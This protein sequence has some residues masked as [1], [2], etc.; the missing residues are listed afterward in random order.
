MSSCTKSMCDPIEFHF[1][2]FFFYLQNALSKKEKNL[3]CF[4]EDLIWAMTGE[5]KR[6]DGLY[7]NFG[8]AIIEILKFFFFL[9]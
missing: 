5:E 1:A 8:L 2:Y 9:A 6:L 3:K 4:R 7:S